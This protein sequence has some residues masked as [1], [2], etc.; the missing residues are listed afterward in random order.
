LIVA[1]F[2]HL[3]WAV[4]RQLEIVAAQTVAMGVRIGKQTSLNKKNSVSKANEDQ[5]GF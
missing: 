4:D 3:E 5:V 1:E 2:F